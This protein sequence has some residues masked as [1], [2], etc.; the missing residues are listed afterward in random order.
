MYVA[1]AGEGPAADAVRGALADADCEVTDADPGGVADAGADRAVVTGLAGSG[2]F[3]AANE[4]ATGAA[5][6]WIAVEAGGVAGEGFEGLRAAAAGFAPGRGCYDCLRARVTACG[7]G[8]ADPRTSTPDRRL[9]GALAGREAVR[10]EPFAGVIE[11]PHRRRSFL[12]APDCPTCGGGPDR[13]LSRGYEELPLEDVLAR[14]ERAVDDRLGVV[15]AVGERESYPAP[16]Y[17]ATNCDTTA[18]S[19][20]TAGE[21]AAG[22]DTDWNRAYVKAVGEALE[23]YAAATYRER[24]FADEP[25]ARAVPPGRF[26]RPEDADPEPAV[27]WH[28][29]MDLLVDGPVSL[30]AE[31][32]RFPP[33]AER[34]RPAITTGLGLGSSTDEAALSGLYE[35]LERDAAMLAWYSTFDP[36]GIDA[37]EEFGALA[38][39]A[40]SEGLSVTPLLLTQDVDVPVA[41]VTLRRGE[42]PR[43]A[44][45]SAAALDAAAAARSALAEAVQNWMELRALGPEQAAEAGE[46]VARYADDPSPVDG[47]DDPTTTVDAA[48]VGTTVPGSEELDALLDRVA[49]AGLDAYAA[50]VT[51]RDA[52]ALGFE[53]V[54][55]LV[56]SAQPLFVGEPYFGERARSVPRELGFEPRLDRARHPFP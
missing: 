1:V 11:V 6:P 12:S 53:V 42:W 17:L 47:F 22:V 27:S 48:S 31:L 14:A 52:A 2:R 10:E 46:A 54:R 37:G 55:T 38:R 25:D 34:V 4:A 15:T 16:Y 33:P 19:D 51:T 18:F 50:R 43:F 29:G 26:V 24:S 28:P 3:E 30:P 56:P 39:R 44:A 21:Q 45:G 36:V 9:A 49:E 35:V 5:L 41:A 23:R 8:D 13:E 7:G 20:A 32:V 40:R